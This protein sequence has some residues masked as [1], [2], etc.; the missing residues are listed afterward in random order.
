MTTIEAH[1]LAVDYADSPRALAG[2]DLTVRG[3]ELVVVLGPNGSG[4]S[5]LV[6]CLAG[7]L[8]PDEGEVRLDGADVL[9]MDARERSRSIAVLP[10]EL[11]SLTDVTV[12]AFAL[13]GRYGHLG[14]LRRPLARDRE[15]VQRA[16]ELGD[17]ADLAERLVT[18]LSGGQRQR[19]L[20]ARAIAQEASLWL[21]DE[22][23]SSLDPEHQLSVFA[24]LSRE[25]HEAGRGALVVTHDLNLAS[26]FAT[27]V[28]LLERGRLVAEGTAAEVLRPEVLEPVY[29]PDLVYGT[30]RSRGAGEK[31]FVLPWLE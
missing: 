30:L 16:L 7:I 31:P 10:Q 4:K 1:G 20:L 23:T 12:E 13:G 8:T 21:V 11:R 27:R 6:K 22:P 5:T 29:G 3:G 17:A 26:Q 18:E 2:V 9:R 15:L 19:V 28:L 25:V 14:L 24:L